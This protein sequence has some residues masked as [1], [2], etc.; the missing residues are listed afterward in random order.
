MKNNLFYT[1]IIFFAMI[2]TTSCADANLND[3]LPAKV[4]KE[5]NIT[6]LKAIITSFDSDL[7]NGKIKMED[8]KSVASREP[9][10][11][12]CTGTTSQGY[13]GSVEMTD[14][15]MFTLT[16]T[17]S[18]GFTKTYFLHDLGMAYT[19]CDML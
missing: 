5:E 8:A 19:A 15:G 4:T 6:K 10:S 18:D 3:N 13:N 11:V 12:V 9:N 17:S 1:A 7:K 14:Y 16:L 2:L